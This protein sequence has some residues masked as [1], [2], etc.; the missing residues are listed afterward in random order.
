MLLNI[1]SQL[2]DNGVIIKLVEKIKN[3]TNFFDYS[4]VPQFVSDI[5]KGRYTIWINE[6]I[7]VLGQ[8]KIYQGDK[9]ALSLTVANLSEDKALDLQEHL[10]QIEQEAKKIGVTRIILDG[11][12]GWK[13]VFPDYKV[14]S[15]ILTKEI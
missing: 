9:I 6:Q 7:V 8:F 13:K 4:S 10:N 11:R 12:Y 5:K 15:V 2:V 3:K 14:T 1:P